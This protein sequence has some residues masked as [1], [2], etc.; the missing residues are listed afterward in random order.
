MTNLTDNARRT[1]ESRR[2]SAPSGEAF[3]EPGS[4]NPRKGGAPRGKTTRAARSAA[5]RAAK[6]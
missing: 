1:L 3:R 6:S 4:L 2:R 5:S